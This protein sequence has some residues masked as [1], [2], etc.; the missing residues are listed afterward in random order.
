MKISHA[1][2][3]AGPGLPRRGGSRPGDKTAGEFTRYI[4]LRPS[5]PRGVPPA[6]PLAGLDGVLAIQEVPDATAERRRAVRRGH[7]LLDELR[8]L[9]LGLI[10]GRLSEGVLRGL[11]ARLQEARPAVDD[12]KLASVL[13]QIEIRAAV[14][15]AKLRRDRD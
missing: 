2:P 1:G 3:S 7:G 8:A 10:E 13:D 4:D 15:M 5:P 6:T 11:A 9:Q 14:E 12:P